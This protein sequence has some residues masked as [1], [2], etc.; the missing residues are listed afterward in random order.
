MKKYCI[1]GMGNAVR[2]LELEVP[3]SF[4]SELNVEKGQM[5]LVD[6]DR[7]R[8][9]LHHAKELQCPEHRNC[10]GSAANTLIAMADLGAK[11]F[12]NCKLAQDELGT[13]YLQNLNQHGVQTNPHP[14]SLDEDSLVTA[15][16][17]VMITPDAER[18]MNTHLGISRQFS[19]EDIVWDDLSAS[20]YLYIEGYLASV[21]EGKEAAIAAVE[22]ARSCGVK[23]VLSFSDPAMAKF[24]SSELN[25]IMGDQKIDFLFCNEEEALLFTGKENISEAKRDLANRA[26]AFAITQ[27]PRGACIWDGTEEWNVSAPAVRAVDTNGAGDIFAGVYLYTLIQGHPHPTAGTLASRAASCLVSRFGTRL[28]QEELEKIYY[29]S[30]QGNFNVK[31]RSFIKNLFKEEPLDCEITVAGW[32]RSIR[33]SKHF[34]FLV[35]NDG[36]C[37]QD[38]QIIVDKDMPGH[39]E[40]SGFLTGTSVSIRG[41]L[42]PSQGKGQK[43]EMQAARG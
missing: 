28:P 7:Q 4:L 5:A 14:S 35:L 19:K 42:R 1:Y 27:G 20:E 3:F 2:D 22:F 37:Q 40:A 36:S 12:Y 16:C 32:V 41:V 6:R 33:K 21:L 30:S 43:V 31:N 24:H 26:H 38:L 34:S 15:R 11:I 25:E 18:T 23:T 39:E 29:D 8:E 17:L 10:G 13:L 9:L